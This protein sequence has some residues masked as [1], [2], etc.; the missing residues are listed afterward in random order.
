MTRLG[1]GIAWAASFVIV[2]SLGT[3][4]WSQEPESSPVLATVNEQPITEAD[5]EFLSFTRRVPEK[6]RAAVRERLIA[7][8]IDQKL[9]TAFLESRSIQAQP[10]E[11]ASRIA[12]IRALIERSGR[13]PEEVY[14]KLGLS[15]ALL[16][17]TLALPLAWN[18]HVRQ[19]VTAEQVETYFREHQRRLDGSKLRVSQIVRT[20]PA[21]ASPEARRAAVEFLASL[22]KEIASG[23]IRFDDAA[24]EHSQSPSGERGGDIG[25]IGAGTGGNVPE[26]LRRAAYTLQPGQVSEPVTSRFGVHLVTITESVPGQLSLEDVRGEVLTELGEQLWREELE[27][28]RAAAK[29]VR[30]GK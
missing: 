2:A 20:L 19:V 28:Q 16:G 27:R 26:E 23:K 17:R 5:L 24:K 3:P 6:E 9:M 30:P 18:R 8:L 4:L 11:I 10:E 12:M 22:Q 21:D 1:L 7:E 29:I 15:E 14:Q 13:K 25:W